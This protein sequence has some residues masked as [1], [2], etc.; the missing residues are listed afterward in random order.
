METPGIFEN[1]NLEFDEDA[2]Y[3]FIENLNS[4]ETPGFFYWNLKLDG[5][6][7][8]FWKLNI[9]FYEKIP[10]ASIPTYTILSTAG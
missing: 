6:A 1:W 2:W 5:D 8:Y 7:R 10:G 4:I 9:E 3:F